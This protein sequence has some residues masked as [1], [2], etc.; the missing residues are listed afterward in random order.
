M[1]R[2]G[3]PRRELELATKVSEFGERRTGGGGGVGDAN[4]ESS[5]AGGADCEE[6]DVDLADV[7]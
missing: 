6:T 2:P 5:E 1:M 4:S 3:E 7:C